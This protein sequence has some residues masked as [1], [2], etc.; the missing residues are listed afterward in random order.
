MLAI[1]WTQ[2]KYCEIFCCFCH[3]RW[4]GALE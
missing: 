3:F 2:S 1:C 4:L